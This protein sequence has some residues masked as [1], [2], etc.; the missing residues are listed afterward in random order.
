MYSY[1]NILIFIIIL[2]VILIFANIYYKYN[3]DKQNNQIET[4]QEKLT[5]ILNE[6]IKQYF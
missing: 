6:T 4:E 3:C 5:R 2:G 1:E